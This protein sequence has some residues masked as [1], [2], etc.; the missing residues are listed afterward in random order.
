[1]LDLSQAAFARR[2]VLPRNTICLLG[3]SRIASQSAG[4]ATFGSDNFIS[5]A[6]A[7]LGAR[8]D[9]LYNG[10]TAGYR[11]DRYLLNL[12]NAIQSVASWAMV[13][14]I[15]NDLVAGY[16]DTQ[17][18]NGYDAGSGYYTSGMKAALDALVQ[19]GKHVIVCTEY[20]GGLSGT[21][22]NATQIAYLHRYNQRLREYAERQPGVVLFDLAR[23][24]WD[25]TS[26]SSSIVLK[27]GYS[28]DGTHFGHLA[29]II[30]G[31]EFANLLTHLMPD[32]AD[33]FVAMSQQASP[34]ANPGVNGLPNPLFLT[35]TGGTANTGISGTVPSGWTA[36]RSGSATATI[37]TAANADGAG[38]DLVVAATFTA[39]E[40]YIRLDAF[41]STS[42]W[43]TGDIFQ[44]G[45]DIAVDAASSNF[46]GAT[47]RP[48]V[49]ATAQA[50]VSDL[51][52]SV[53]T[54]AGPTTAYEN[55][56]KTPP[57]VVG[58][59]AVSSVA[60]YLFLYGTG[61]GTVT[62]RIS[63]PWLQKRFEALPS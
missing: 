60:W 54:Q 15:F 33:S 35:T 61:V 58:A 26:T 62:A 56:L 13:F 40:E 32:V 12:P 45:V 16:T 49:Q 3:D 7:A 1:M 34:I 24:A 25:Q 27:S 53:H 4:T 43:A 39:A 30:I 20:A 18:W 29:S 21:L 19:A 10:A 28:S 63:R 8:F 6:R 23:L 5:Q 57:N 2:L 11:S 22:L 59:G 42:G 47:L 37:S 48:I 41:P 44:A 51:F 52:A 38:N 9:V 55:R 50:P 17:I 36:S 14:G 31:L 46:W